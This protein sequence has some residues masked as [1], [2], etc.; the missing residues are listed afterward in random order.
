M[1]VKVSTG[2]TS[3][4]VSKSLHMTRSHGIAALIVGSHARLRAGRISPFGFL[5]MSRQRT[6]AG[7]LESS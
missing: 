1:A 2:Q 6:P 3:N 5:E 4:V 7:V